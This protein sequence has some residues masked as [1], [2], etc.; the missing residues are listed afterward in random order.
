VTGPSDALAAC[1]D[2]TRTYGR[3]A[4]RVVALHEVSCQVRPGQR[5]AVT[6]E[7]GSG[8]STLLHVLA[9]LE[10]PSS[11][12]VTWPGLAMRGSRPAGVGIVFQAPSLLPM[13]DV[14]DNVALPLLLVDVPAA[15]A[16]DR[17]LAVLDRL[18]IADLAGA[19]PEELSGGQAQRVALA[20]VLAEEPALVLAD[21]PTGQLDRR[22]ADT[23]LT[24]LLQTVDVLGAA[25][26]LSTHDLAVAPRH[27][28]Q[29]AMTDGRLIDVLAGKATP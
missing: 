12:T 22:T 10:S 17:A 2:V 18:G 29:W 16:R 3:G 25:H 7:S 19:A 13:L 28:E 14:A 5:I 26:V 8:K 4:A 27:E 1:Q 9:G 6:G 11:G 23:V 20:R 21:E 24:V 15:R